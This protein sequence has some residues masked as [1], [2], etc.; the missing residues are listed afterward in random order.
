MVYEYDRTNAVNYARK[1]AL[2]NNPCFGNFDAIGGDCTAFVSEC[3]F[4]GSGYMNFTPDLGWYY[5]SMKDRAAAW[6]GVEFLYNFLTT[7]TTRAVFGHEADISETM[8]GDIIQLQNESGDFYHSVIVTSTGRIPTPLNIL[9]ASHSNNAL[10]KVLRRYPY[11][12]F[13]VIHI[14][15]YYA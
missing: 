12:N 15:G 2:S 8:P 1:W 7:N 11:Y 9:V 13:R 5:V 14:D 3:L 10:D 6:S 4:A